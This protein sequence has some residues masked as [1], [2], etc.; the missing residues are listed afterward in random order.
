MGAAGQRVARR[1]VAAADVVEVRHAALVQHV[2]RYAA[3]R[4]HVHR[5]GAVLPR[6]KRRIGGGDEEEPRLPDQV[7]L[8]TGDVVEEICHRAAQGRHRNRRGRRSRG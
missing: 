3:L 8:L 1:L 5:P 7:G 6:R 2:E 4:R